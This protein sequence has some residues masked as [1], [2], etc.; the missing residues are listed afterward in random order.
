M[1]PSYQHTRLSPGKAAFTGP[2]HRH[3]S[4]AAIAGVLPGIV[5]CQD[6]PAKP[7]PKGHG[8]GKP[9]ILVCVVS[10]AEMAKGFV[11][12]EPGLGQVANHSIYSCLHLGGIKGTTARLQLL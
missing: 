9:G 7:A 12:E 3:I 11:N 10:L 2:L 4:I 1:K 5:D 6:I 8:F